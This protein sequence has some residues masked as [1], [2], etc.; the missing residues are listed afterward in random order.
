MLFVDLF[1][2]D[3]ICYPILTPANIT[4]RRE[5]V[6][7]HHD[8]PVMGHPGVFKTLELI[9][10][11]YWWPGLYLFIKRFVS[12]CAICQQM[13]VNTHPSSPPLNP[14]KADPEALPFSTVTVDFITD[15]PPSNGYD[16]LMVMVDHD[17]SKGIILAPCQKTIDALGTAQ[18][19]HDY[20]Y[21]RFGLPKKII[22]DRGPQFA[23]KTF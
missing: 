22:S 17:L 6:A 3:A 1:S 15:L 9:R 13:K 8:L 11:N 10:Q 18:L 5:V 12:G 21:K 14:I 16:A 23:S 19:L 4:L 7:M 20:L 2:N